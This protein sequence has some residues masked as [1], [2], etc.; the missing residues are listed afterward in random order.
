MRTHVPT[1][2]WSKIDRRSDTECWPWLGNL[3]PNGYG[4]WSLAG[5]C[6]SPHRVVYVL[7]HG[8]LPSGLFVCHHCDNPRCCNPAH[9]Y[10]GTPAQ[11]QQDAIRRNRR[12]SRAGELHPLSKLTNSQREAIVRRRGAG[13]RGIDLAREFAVSPPTITRLVKEAIA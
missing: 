8:E 11:N 2:V 12:P 13:E 10:A 9:L 7:A 4:Q 1:D 6:V 3:R 5:R